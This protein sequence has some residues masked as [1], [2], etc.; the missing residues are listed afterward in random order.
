MH[1]RGHKCFQNSDWENEI[2]EGGQ[3][4]MRLI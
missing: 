1:G 2:D 4:W 3:V